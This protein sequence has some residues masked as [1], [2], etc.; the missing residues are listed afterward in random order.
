MT[1][2]YLDFVQLVSVF[3]GLTLALDAF[4]EN[5][6]QAGNSLRRIRGSFDV[7][8]APPPAVAAEGEAE[9]VGEGAGSLQV[10]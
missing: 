8:P 7:S 10:S 1:W 3:V 4:P 5:W 2:L 9:A 6:R